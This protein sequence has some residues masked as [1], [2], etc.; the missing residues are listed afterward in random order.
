VG[1]KNL[2]IG[3][4]EVK[5]RE[6]PPVQGLRTPQ[7]LE[8]LV[9]REN[10]NMPKCAKAILI[11][12][13]V[14]LMSAMSF[15]IASAATIQSSAV[16]KG[17]SL[18][19]GLVGHWTF[20]GADISGVTAYDKAGTNNGTITAA[21]KVIGKLGQGM[22][23][24]GSSAHIYVG[25]GSG[26]ALGTQYTVSAWVNIS[27]LSAD[28]QIFTLRNNAGQGIK[29]QLDSQSGNTFNFIVRDDANH[30]AVATKSMTPKTNRWYYVV[31]VRNGNNIYV[32]VDT[33]VGGTVGSASLGTITVNKGEI[34]A[35][36]S[37]IGVLEISFKGV[38]DDVRIYSRA[39]SAQEIRQLYAMGGDKI[40]ASTVN[41]GGSLTSGLVGHWTFDGADISGTQV[42]DK[43]PQGTNTGTSS[44]GVTKVM[45]KLGQAMKFN[46]STGNTSISSVMGLST[47]DVTISHWVKLPSLSTKGQ[48]VRV[49]GNYGYGTG[50][51][52]NTYD[53]NGNNLIMLFGGIRWI[54]TSYNFTD[55]KWHYITMTINSAG[56]PAIYVDGIY[57]NSY[58]GTSATAPD[59]TTYIGREAT[60]RYFNG[61]IDDVRIY[62]RALS[63][64]EVRQLYAMGG[65]KIQ[66]STV[67]KGGSLTSGLVGHWT[68]DGADISGTTVYDKASTNN[69]TSS[70]GV[71]KVMGK[72]GQSYSFNGT[73]GKI[74]L[75][76][77]TTGATLTM[78]CWW[79]TKSTAQQSC[80]N[81]YDAT[82]GVYFGIQGGGT[83][84]AY[85]TNNTPNVL[86]GPGGQTFSDGKW[87]H[88]VYTNDGTRGKLYIDGVLVTNESQT[89]VSH[90]GTGSIGYGGLAG[91]WFNGSID[92]IRIYSRALSASE[93]RQLYA[94]GK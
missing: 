72:L 51:G 93:V 13:A 42:Y 30:I 49:G 67:N 53:A 12:S 79:K 64:T 37:P 70:G 60:G 50:V 83:L 69:G 15:R 56:V 76:S 71:T 47:A 9:I 27:D 17:G 65:D 59:D 20:D 73:S 4:P 77:F 66:A 48:F 58:S 45:G 29:F 2:D 90:T 14:L 81:N 35:L 82:S 74:A 18:T 1:I 6:N 87:H 3:C 23:F 89:R 25:D 52:T 32:Y 92:D 28:R 86:N 11:C 57:I 24:N 31:G 94:M 80:F 88:E 63:A 33:V 16:N 19:S 55:T 46:G 41:K 78:S 39:L 40:Q 54:P 68:F 34:G 44:G 43:S 91:D 62:S 21:T 75:P 38:I 7:G 10:P 36:W 22:R 5:I 61:S 8:R 84:F 26:F 85:S